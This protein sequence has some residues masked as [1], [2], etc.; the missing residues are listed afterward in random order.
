MPGLEDT[1]H[2]LEAYCR[3]HDWAGFD[4]YDALNSELFARTPLARSRVARLALT[5]ALKRSP[6]NIRPLLRIPPQRDPKATAL[7]LMSYGKR[8]QR[9]DGESR[10]IAS[11]LAGRLMAL[12]SPATRY[13]CWG[14]S[15]PWQTRSILVPRFYPNLVTTVFAANA[16][17]DA[18]EIELGADCLNAAASAVEYLAKELYWSDG[19]RAGFGYPRPDN[20]VGVHNANF[21]GAALLSRLARLTGDRTVVDVALRVA[22]YSASS[23]RADGSWLYGEAPTLNWIDNFHTGYNLCAL[24]SIGASLG[25]D[26]FEPVLQKGFGFYRE[27][28]FTPGSAPKY[29][30]DRTYPID[31]HSVAQ[32]MITLTA[33][34]RQ[35]SRAEVLAQSVFAWAMKN[36]WDER[37][38]FYYRILRSVTIRT[39]YMRWSEAWMLL[40]LST[41]VNESDSGAASDGSSQVR[42]RPGD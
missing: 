33:F 29:Y 22:R 14:Y 40:A 42:S 4:P 41:I 7:F 28:F 26:E 3:A 37:G 31:I 30:H 8:A 2:K 5:Q 38:F 36:M 12:R 20:R 34:C 9:G 35:D 25:T 13:W 32:S 17:L 19:R 1:I 16:L 6:V 21:L 10:A 27:H 11:D 39:P 15:F 23:Q 24:Q 18:Y